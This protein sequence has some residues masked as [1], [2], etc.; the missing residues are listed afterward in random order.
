KET[1]RVKDTLDLFYTRLLLSADPEVKLDVDP[2]KFNCNKCF[3]MG[4]TL[5]DPAATRTD[6]LL[7]LPSAAVKEQAKLKV[8]NQYDATKD[9][10]LAAGATTQTPIELI[11][12]TA[13]T[14]LVT[15]SPKLFELPPACSASI[16]LPA[17]EPV[18]LPPLASVTA[19]LEFA[20]LG[21]L[22]AGAA[23]DV[24][25]SMNNAGTGETLADYWIKAR[26][27][28]ACDLNLDGRVDIDDID[29]MMSY[30]NTQI[31]RA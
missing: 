12:D 29:L 31:G 13:E 26:N 2:A 3:G 6:F 21:S 19:I 14:T 24:I 1:V 22:P 25:F 20:C 18:P 27:P 28:I 23:A 4:S 10:L 17:P 11:K 9:I 30:R 8:A 16:L 5:G 15:L 7:N